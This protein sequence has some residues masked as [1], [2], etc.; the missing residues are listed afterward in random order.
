M[1]SPDNAGMTL[2]TVSPRS[3][4]VATTSERFTAEMSQGERSSLTFAAPRSTSSTASKAE[5]S[6][7]TLFTRRFFPT[8]SDQSIDDTLAR[9]LHLGE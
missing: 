9:L 5:A 3:T 2:S 8:L 4:A 1:E 7:T 6:R